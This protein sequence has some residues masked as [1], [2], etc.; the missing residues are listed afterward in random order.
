[1]T[2]TG[3]HPARY[4]LAGAWVGATGVALLTLAACGSSGGSNAATPPSSAE[5]VGVKDLCTVITP[6]DAVSVFGAPGTAQPSSGSTKGLSGACLYKKD[7]TA[8][9]VDLLQ[10][11]V[12]DG[13]QFYGEKLFKHP[14][15]VEIVGA[16]RAFER[17]GTA[18]GGAT[19]YDLQ[20]LKD[21]KT[22]AIN[23]VATGGTSST[24]S[25]AALR[26]VADKLAR[27]L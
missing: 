18:K 8:P 5:V 1:M 7:G 24:A 11:R 3:Q 23:Y 22:G 2:V 21:G 27:N 4:G 17:V 13:P 19:T 20:F 26:S 6:A 14:E 9:T 15:P 12:Y 10:V 16:D 25:S